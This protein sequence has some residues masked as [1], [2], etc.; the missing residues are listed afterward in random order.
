MSSRKVPEV[1]FS[2]VSRGNAL[3][4]H[5]PDDLE[6]YLIEH[7]DEELF[8]HIELAAK[9]SQ[10]MQM[11]KFYHRVILQCAVIGYTA[12]GYEGVDNVKA[13]YLL[14]SEF[15]KDF[16]KGPKGWEPIILDKRNM[17]KARL[18]KYLEDCIFFI[19]N[20]LQQGVPDSE[21]YKINKA[22]GKNFRPVER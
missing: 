21:A 18:H 17:T 2:A 6:R 5:N 20:E 7:R 3:V 12:V 16:I 22:T 14:R 8:I 19:E 10:K 13:D 11:Y 4:W 1:I 15:A 9:L